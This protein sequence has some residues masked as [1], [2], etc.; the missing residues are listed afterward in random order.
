MAKIKKTKGKLHL[1]GQKFMDRKL[2]AAEIGAWLALVNLGIYLLLSLFLMINLRL[3]VAWVLIVIPTFFTAFWLLF[4]QM[5]VRFYHRIAG[6]D[7]FLIAKLS[8]LPFV[9]I[10]MFSIIN[11]TGVVVNGI[12]S[13]WDIMWYYGLFSSVGLIFLD[14]VVLVFGFRHLI[15]I[16]TVAGKISEKTAKS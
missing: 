8:V 16:T 11:L 2:H 6:H 15:H 7:M 10:F 14:F 5:V 13:F 3:F 4:S 1:F 9:I 12:S